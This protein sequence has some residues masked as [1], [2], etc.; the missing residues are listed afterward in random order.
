MNDSLTITK[1]Q[2]LK[3]FIDFSFK[4][5]ADTEAKERHLLL[6]KFKNLEHELDGIKEQLAEELGSKDDVFRK[7]QK[8]AQEADM[9]RQKY[10][11]DGL[12]KAEELEMSKM[13][14]QARLTEAQGTI[15]QLDGKLNQVEKAR[16]KLQAEVEEMALQ[17]D[18]AHILNSAMEKKAKQFD[19]C[20]CSI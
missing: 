11:K 10:E 8:A 18:Q 17:T 20:L 19:R 3:Y 16:A 9:W 7:L 2:K 15:E 12:A 5:V 14:L 4:R 13:K 6:G 1:I